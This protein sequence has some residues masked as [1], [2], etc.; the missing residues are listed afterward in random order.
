MAAVG[1][2]SVKRTKMDSCAQSMESKHMFLNKTEERK[3][4]VYQLGSVI[5]D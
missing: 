3:N 1:Q 5:K 4:D 2:S